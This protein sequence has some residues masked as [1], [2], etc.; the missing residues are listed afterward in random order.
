MW[1]L[2]LEGE[3]QENPEFKSIW[4]KRIVAGQSLIFQNIY[5]QLSENQRRVLLAI[6]VLKD[7]D[8]LFSKEIRS[9]NKLPEVSSMTASI[10]SLTKKKLIHKVK[11]SYEIINPVFEEW[12]KSL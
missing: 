4:L 5:D 9:K 3:D 1:D 6:S 10:K 12:V 8:K 11:G 7:D 2:I